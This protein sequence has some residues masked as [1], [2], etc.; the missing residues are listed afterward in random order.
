MKRLLLS[1]F[2]VLLVALPLAASASILEN[3]LGDIKDPQA[4]AIRILQVFLGFLAM[5]GLIMFIYG[6]FVMLTSGGNADR[7]KK[8]KGTLVW[9]AAGIITILASYSILRFVFGLLT[10]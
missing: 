7:I 10:E 9:A 4:L 2:T 5:I 6:G 8:A 1:G 3:P